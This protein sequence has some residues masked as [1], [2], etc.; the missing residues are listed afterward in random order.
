MNFDFTQIPAGFH[1][2]NFNQAQCADKDSSPLH[3][4]YFL[5]FGTT[6]VKKTNINFLAVIQLIDQ[7]FAISYTENYFTNIALI[8][9]NQLSIS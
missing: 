6:V 3:G 1:L 5:K 4:K 7:N 9:I 8:I 2:F